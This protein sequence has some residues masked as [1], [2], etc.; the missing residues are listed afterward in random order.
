MSLKSVALLIMAAA[1][2]VPI[3]GPVACCALVVDYPIRDRDWN[4]DGETSVS[5]FFAAVDVGVRP[6]ACGERFCLEYFSFK[7]GLKISIVCPGL[8]PAHSCP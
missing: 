8:G 7:D 2:F 3:V 6:I 4:L 1:I 5:E